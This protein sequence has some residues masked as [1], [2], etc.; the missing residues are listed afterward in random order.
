MVIFYLMFL[1]ESEK[2]RTEMFAGIKL[3]IYLLALPK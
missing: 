2:K 1:K 3:I